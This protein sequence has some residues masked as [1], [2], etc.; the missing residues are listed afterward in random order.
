[1]Q[2]LLEGDTPAKQLAQQSSDPESVL[3]LMVGKT[4]WTTLKKY[5]K[6]WDRFRRW[7]II[8]GMPAWPTEPIQL[9][10]YLQTLMAE[11]CGATVP[12]TF[13][14]AA[15]WVEKAAGYSDHDR[16]SSNP[17]IVKA[18]ERISTLLTAGSRP[19]KQ[20]P[21]IPCV[22]M[23]AAELYV[24][25]ESYP[26]FL[27][28]SAWLLLVKIWASLRHDDMQHIVPAQVKM[29]EGTLVATITQSKTS[30]PGKR[31]RELPVIIA[32]GCR[33]C[34]T[35]WL[36]T[37]FGLMKELF[38]DKKEVDYLIPR[39]STG[40]GGSPLA[41]ASYAEASAAERKL[42]AELKLPA[43]SLE[44]GWREDGVALLAPHFVGFW[45]LHSPRTFMP[46][47]LIF[48]DTEKSKRDMV[49]RWSPS[50]SDDYSRTFRAAVAKM[51]AQVASALHEG[52]GLS[53]MKDSDIVEKLDEFLR[54]RRFMSSEQAE[55]QVA[56]L[57][58]LM[59]DFHYSLQAAGADIPFKTTSVEVPLVQK[60]PEVG[61][62]ESSDH[63]QGL[64]GCF[65][66]IYTRGRKFARLHKFGSCHWSMIEVHDSLR[67]EVVTPGQYDSR[68]KFC[69]PGTGAGQPARESSG[70]SQEES[71]EPAF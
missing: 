54:D 22:I 33:L 18:V 59:C 6:V 38:A 63:S 27:R 39:G 19:K 17:L 47:M 23:A 11:P 40:S 2:L 36:S 16:L 58:G 55:S 4:R 71:S 57:S 69:W 64:E 48:L 3:R 21:R 32:R 49:G 26:V 51:Q 1:M 61:T 10:E 53:T 46:S 20:S 29:I 68:C 25:R 8:G 9:V 50:G 5:I 45:T 41:P 60:L 13:I 14:Q 37:G 34:G 44:G 30:G 70:D 35:P 31:L 66:I 43:W 42:F 56:L 65:L 24:M 67:V 62:Q 52:L 15:S 12:Q 28:Y 7:L